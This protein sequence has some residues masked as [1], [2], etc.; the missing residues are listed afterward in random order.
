MPELAGLIA[1]TVVGSQEK[2]T[3]K[4]TGLTVVVR[5]PIASQVDDRRSAGDQV[6]G[7]A[8]QVESRQARRDRLLQ[9]P[10]G[11]ANIGASYLNVAESIN[12]ILERLAKEGYDVGD[13][14]SVGGHDVLKD[15]TEQGAQR[16][17][18]RA[19]RAEETLVDQESAVR[20][21][22]D[23]YNAVAEGLTPKFR[24]KLLKDWGPPEKSS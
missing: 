16:R 24:A 14:R 6:C 7:P 12:N 20:I 17:R 9:L 4:D 3:D 1:P 10:A 5:K 11:K 15:L 21:P 13:P 19:R 2:V 18:L 8:V 22:V 23:Q